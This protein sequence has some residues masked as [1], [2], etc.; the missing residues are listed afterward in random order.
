LASGVS[1]VP[2][3]K[4]E[5]KEQRTDGYYFGHIQAQSPGYSH[6]KYKKG[7]FFCQIGRPEVWRKP[8]FIF[9]LDKY[10]KFL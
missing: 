4:A 7:A 3:D 6:E 5:K 10:L 8:N 2:Q 1:R 9:S